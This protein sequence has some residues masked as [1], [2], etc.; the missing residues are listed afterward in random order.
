MF[1]SFIF[2]SLIL[3]P[4]SSLIVYVLVGVWLNYAN[5]IKLLDLPNLRSSHSTAIPRSGGLPVV[6]IFFVV[7]TYLLYIQ[8][9]PV[10]YFFA[11]F[12]GGFLI[13]LV[14]L[15]DDFFQIALWKRLLVHF[16]A[17]FSSI[18]FLG[19]LAPIVVY[20]YTFDFGLLSDVIIIIFLVWMI[21]LYNF[22]D[23][24]NGIASIETISVVFAVALLYLMFDSLLF[25]SWFPPL[26]L[27]FCV[28]GFL[29]WNFP[30]AKIFLGDVGSGFLGFNIGVFAIYS[31][32]DHFNMFWAW[33]ILLGVFIVDSTFT[34]IYRILTGEK[35]YTA[36]NQHL[37]QI[38][39]N[40]F[41]SQKRVSLAVA[42][43]NIFWLL[44]I[45]YFVSSQVLEGILG[46]IIAY[47]PLIGTSIYYRMNIRVKN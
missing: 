28:I 5:R 12:I 15:L 4:I 18:Y 13:S 32:W 1:D 34:L 22:M 23:G 6:C 31:S 41:S 3:L 20:D 29:F 9:V 38:L 8:L 42:A 47:T 30:N 27:G 46:M 40:H 36:H 19:G 37:Y 14:G 26:F 43:T 44:P 21:N 17:S 24:I 33:L 35:F 11:L 10:K 7:L 16:I 39:S 25:V 45:A 2:N